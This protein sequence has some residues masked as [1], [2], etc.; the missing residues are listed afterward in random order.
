ML[1][2]R[3]Q[4]HYIPSPK[5]SPS[6]LPPTSDTHREGGEPFLGVNGVELEAWGRRPS[7]PA[8]SSGT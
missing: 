4:P 5:R 2:S 7:S 1:P 6:L 8:L 3:P